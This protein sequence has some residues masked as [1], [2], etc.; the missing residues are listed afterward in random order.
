MHKTQSDPFG[1]D[2]LLY[3]LNVKRVFSLCLVLEV[4]PLCNINMYCVV[5]LVELSVQQPA[6]KVYLYWVIELL[7]FG[8]E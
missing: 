3:V 6:S 7:H 5:E 2:E 8:D 1:F 4:S